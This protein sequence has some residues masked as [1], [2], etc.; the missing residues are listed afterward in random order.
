MSKAWNKSTPTSPFRLH[1][2]VCLRDG[3]K[4]QTANSP[5]SESH[6]FL[7]CRQA[8]APARSVSS[9]SVTDDSMAV[10]TAA[11]GVRTSTSMIRESS[12]LL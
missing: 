4:G 8:E 1:A 9:M 2:K 12:T 6:F 7:D 10:S 11:G 5:C 3:V